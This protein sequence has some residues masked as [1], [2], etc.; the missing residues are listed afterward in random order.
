MSGRIADIAVNPKKHSEWIIA[1]AS[2]HL[3]KT[4]NER[5]YMATGFCITMADIFYGLVKY[6]P[7]N[8]FVIWAGTGEGNHQRALGYGNGIYKSTDGG[9]SWKNMG[10]KNSR[11]IG[12]IL[13]DSRNSEVVY[14]GCEGSVWGP[15]GDR[16]LFKTT[17]GGKTWNKILNISENTGVNNIICDPRNPDVLYATSEQRRRHVFTRSVEDP[18]GFV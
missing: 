18:K 2:G 3:W 9:Q 13:I 14:V 6:D 5:N 8:Q 17:D 16:G 12:S 4:T 11:Q 10:L 15:G 1:V 7:N